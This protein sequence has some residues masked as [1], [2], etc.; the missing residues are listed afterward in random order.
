MRDELGMSTVQ[1]AE[2]VR[3]PKRTVQRGLKWAREHPEHVDSDPKLTANTLKY[4][5]KH[6]AY[7][8]DPAVQEWLASSRRRAD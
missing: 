6:S 8:N 3:A 5:E 2:Q 4:V 1:I 7:R